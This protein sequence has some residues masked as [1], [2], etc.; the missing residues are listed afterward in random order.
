MKK[1]SIAGFALLYVVLIVSATGAHSS[2]WAVREFG[3]RSDSFANHHSP[4][5]SKLDR[6][7]T[8]LSQTKIFETGFVVESPLEGFAA[9]ADSKPHLALLSVVYRSTWG[10]RPFSCRAPPSLI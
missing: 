8:R 6:S 9:P 1:F 10:G 2:E 7:D 3:T 4:E 5:F